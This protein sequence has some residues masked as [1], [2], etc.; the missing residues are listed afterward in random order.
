[1]LDSSQKNKP[2]EAGLFHSEPPLFLNQLL[3][4]YHWAPVFNVDRPTHL[5][6]PLIYGWVPLF[7]IGCHPFS[8]LGRATATWK[9][10]I[11]L[12]TPSRL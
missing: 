1:M 12:W 9:A 4:A 8:A 6:T 11:H 10:L 7:T 3:T 5:R 2:P